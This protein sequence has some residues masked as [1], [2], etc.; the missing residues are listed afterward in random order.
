MKVKDIYHCSHCKMEFNNDYN[1][2]THELRCAKKEQNKKGSEQTKNIFECQTCTKHF[3]SEHGLQRH[4]HYCDGE[5]KCQKC[6][7]LFSCK[8][9]LEHHFKTCAHALV[10]DICCM[11]CQTIDL[12]K[13]HV[14]TKHKDQVKY[15]CETCGDVFYTQQ[16]LLAHVVANHQTMFHSPKQSNHFSKKKAS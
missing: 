10:C 16:S 6:H 13:E 14:A 3:T 8:F 9:N 5:M 2:K 4:S 7:K 15:P 12:L 11:R 1:K